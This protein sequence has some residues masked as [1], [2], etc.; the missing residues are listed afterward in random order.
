M[1][2]VTIDRTLHRVE[3][4]AQ[5]RVV[6]PDGLILREHSGTAHRLSVLDAAGYRRQITVATLLVIGVEEGVTVDQ[7][8]P[9]PR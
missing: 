9:R 6:A 2:T 7:V 3:Y 8:A 5:G 1:A 4:D